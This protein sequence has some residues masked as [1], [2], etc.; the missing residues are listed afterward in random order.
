MSVAGCGGTQ[1]APVS[2]ATTPVQIANGPTPS[3]STAIG[4]TG[5]AR[6]HPTKPGPV[7]M[8]MYHVIGHRPASAPYPDL[9][10]S[11]QRFAQQMHA[12]RGAGYHAVTLDAVLAN[13]RTGRR[14][15]RIRSC[16][17][18]TT[19][20]PGSRATPRPCCASSAGLRS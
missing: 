5:L 17:P 4:P 15:R 8:L 12:L 18:S 3:N 19:A 7:P 13:W 16:S 20:T 2:G 10:V 6:V 11:P 14:C 9:W 1:R